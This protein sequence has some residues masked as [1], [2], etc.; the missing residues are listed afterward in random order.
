MTHSVDV[1]V[2][3]WNDAEDANEAVRSALGSV[4]VDVGVIV[5]DNGSEVVFVPAEHD[6]VT[7]IRSDVNLGVGGGRNLGWSHATAP[8]VCFLDS[9]ASLEPSA[10]RRLVHSI[11][12]EPGRGLV[13]PRFSDQAPE[14]GAGRAPTILRKAARGLGLTDRYGQMRRDDELEWQVEFAIGACQLVRRVALE[15]V[16][17]ID[18]QFRFGP[19]DVDLCLRLADAGWTLWQVDAARCRHEARRSSRRLLSK[20]GAAHLAALL[21]HFSRRTRVR[22]AR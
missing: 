15:D 20:R 9:D 18:D 22:L 11:H 8:C 16:G 3:T 1:V 14:V 7:L 17:G 19:E 2:L 10:L 6:R 21:R 12:V 4:G 13:A 5:I